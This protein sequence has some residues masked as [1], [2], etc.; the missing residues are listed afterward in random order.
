MS[1]RILLDTTATGHDEQPR[2]DP[3]RLDAVVSAPDNACPR[4]DTLSDDRLHCRG[5]RRVESRGGLVEQEHARAQHERAHKSQTLLL[6]S[7]K[8]VDVPGSATWR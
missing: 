4:R 2:S 3:T 8:S 5:R 7:R 1:K 6:S